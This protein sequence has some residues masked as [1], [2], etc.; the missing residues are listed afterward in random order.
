MVNGAMMGNEPIMAIFP[1]EHFSRDHDRLRRTE[2]IAIGCDARGAAERVGIRRG[3][4]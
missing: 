1:L 4:H 3:L 2:R